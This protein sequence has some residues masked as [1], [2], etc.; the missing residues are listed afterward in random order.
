MQPRVV[1]ANDKVAA[2]RGRV[3]I[4]SGPMVYCAE[5]QENDF[6]ILN[7]H[8]EP[9]SEIPSDGEPELLYG[10]NE[11]T[12]HVQALGFDAAREVGNQRCEV[13]VDTL[14]CLGT[15]W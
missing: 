8:A 7:P 11:I 6:N 15:S 5:W 14:L 4:K 9:S 1:K 12:T 2:D 3:A 13:D 10:I